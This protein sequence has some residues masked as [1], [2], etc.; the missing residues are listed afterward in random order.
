[1]RVG[2]LFSGIGGLELGLQLAGEDLVVQWFAEAD[3]FC[4]EALAVHWPGVRCYE[5]V[6]AVGADAAPV[7]LVCGGFPCQD[8]STAGSRAGLAGARSGLW[9]EFARVVRDLRPRHVFVE[10][11]PGLLVRGFG[12]VLG[13]LAACGYDAT[14]DVFSAFEVGAP[15]IRRRVFVLARAMADADGER[16]GRREVALQESQADAA[17]K[18][19]GGGQAIADSDGE[20]GDQSGS[21]AGTLCGERPQAPFLPRGEGSVAHPG[22]SRPQGAP[23]ESGG[24]RSSGSGPPL[25]YPDGA[26]REGLVATGF[27]GVEGASRGEPHGRGR[28]EHDGPSW[29][30]WQSEPPVGRVADGFSR[31]MA[32]R[33]LMAFGN[34][35]CPHTAALAWR[36]LGERLDG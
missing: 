8:V 27:S 13:D 36:V 21:G 12:T 32:R 20:H 11:V 23:P 30:N 6:E 35:V 22:A 18:S 14:W 19:S 1:M 25:A 9:R 16:F 3:P 10:N 33:A 34:A 26:R 17:T 28:D 5:S 4:R 24:I 29:E 7:D 31:G 2:S 15:H